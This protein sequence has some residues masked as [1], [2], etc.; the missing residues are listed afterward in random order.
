LKYELQT[1]MTLSKNSQENDAAPHD[2]LVEPVGV[3]QEQ[4]LLRLRR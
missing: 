3:A 2:G 4:N 1:D